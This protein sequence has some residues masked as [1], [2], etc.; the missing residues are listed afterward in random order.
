MSHKIGLAVPS[1]TLNSSMA[2]DWM[3]SWWILN[4][5]SSLGNLQ[6]RLCNHYRQFLKIVLVNDLFYYLPS[7][8][9]TSRWVDNIQTETQ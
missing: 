6:A 9:E 5:M 4:E 3:F 1:S 8:Y 2:N 7:G